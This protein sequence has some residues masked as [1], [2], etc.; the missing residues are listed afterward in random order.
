MGIYSEVI[1]SCGDLGQEYVGYLQTKDFDGCFDQYW[2]SPDGCLFEVHWPFIQ[3]Y[4]KE[5]DEPQREHGRV[6][7]CRFSGLIRLSGRAG[8]RPVWFI[9]GRL[10]TGSG[11]AWWPVP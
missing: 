7:P 8:R 9:D 2:I 3:W 4:G 1:N 11:H 10:I 6:S 5:F